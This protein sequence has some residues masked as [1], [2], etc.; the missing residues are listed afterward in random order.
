MEAH[1]SHSGLSVLYATLQYAPSVGGVGTATRELAERMAARGAGVAIVTADPTWTLPPDEVIR[2]LPVHRE[3]AWPREHD[4]LIAPGL[5]RFVARSGCDVLHVE[6]YQTGVAPLA[7]AAAARAGIPYILTFHG[8]G[9]SQSLRNK[10][11]GLQLKVLRPLL[12]RASALI[13][14]AEWEIDRYS[15]LLDLPRSKFV[16]IPN[17][18]D[19]AVPAEL[20]PVDGT[21]LV[22]IGRL[23]RYKGHHLAIKAL[24]HVV[25]QVPDARLWIAGTGPDG[26]VL[27]ALAVEHGVG[28]RVEISAES[29]RAVFS[30]RVAQ[31]SVGLLLSEFETH[32]MAAME[33]ITLGTPMLVTR[34]GGGLSELVD[35]GQARGVELSDAPATHAA[36]IVDLIRLPPPPLEVSLTTWDEAAATHEALYRAIVAHRRTGTA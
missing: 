6:G 5:P 4:Q 13:A 14:T 8:G 31:A 28:D 2:G 16:L 34:D 30:G 22:S 17:G 23:E 32:P 26:E 20:P 19:I 33:A 11:R 7:M 9:H 18:G 35:K 24:P 21:L 15:E 29:D 10:A 36:A 1:R 25:E 12:A 3:R 27:Q